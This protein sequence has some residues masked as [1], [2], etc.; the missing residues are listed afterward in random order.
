[1]KN[2]AQEASKTVKKKKK[3]R[4]NR[5]RK[6]WRYSQN[7]LYFMENKKRIVNLKDGFGEWEDL[8]PREYK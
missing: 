5:R 2:S 6:W 4:K 8:T 1:M 3:K 7:P